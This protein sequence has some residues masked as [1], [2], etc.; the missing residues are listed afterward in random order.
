MDN[1]HKNGVDGL[2]ILSKEQVLAMEP[3]VQSNVMG[4][5]YCPSAGLTSPY[6]LTI[7]LAENAIANGVIL[8]LL[9]E[10]KAIDKFDGVFTITPRRGEYILL[11]KNQ[12]TLVNHVLFQ[13][14]SEEDEII[15]RCEQ[16]NRS[17]IIE[18]LSRG[19]PICSTDAIKRRTRAGIGSSSLLSREKR[20]FW[21]MLKKN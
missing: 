5:L 10:V 2:A 7:A 19:I 18:A 21:K 1:G 4:A 15:C 17:V 20:D 13:A 16:I 8:K 6:E 3:H 11:H 9:Q 12:G 14:P